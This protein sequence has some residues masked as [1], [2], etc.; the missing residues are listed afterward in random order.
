MRLCVSVRAVG[1]YQQQKYGFS[2]NE[3]SIGAKSPG[4]P[5]VLRLECLHFQQLLVLALLEAFPFA[6][7]RENRAVAHL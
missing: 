1:P 6:S 5:S 2:Y 4:V 3:A 7:L